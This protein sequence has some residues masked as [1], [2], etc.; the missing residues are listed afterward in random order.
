M[1]RQCV[2]SVLIGIIANMLLVSASYSYV[3][4]GSPHCPWAKPENKWSKYING[5]YA[6]KQDPYFSV[7]FNRNIGDL[8]KGRCY[9]ITYFGKKRW[10]ASGRVR[11]SDGKDFRVATR[12]GGAPLR[13]QLNV[14]GAIFSFNEAGEVIYRKDGKLAGQMYC[15]I[16]NECWK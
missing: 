10:V 7:R 14:W 11:G 6:K 1:L 2:S 15:H 16:G 12:H 13:N 3:F 8:E 5:E 4:P 9:T